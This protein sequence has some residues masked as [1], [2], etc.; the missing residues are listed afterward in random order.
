MGMR[1]KDESESRHSLAQQRKVRRVVGTGI[2][3]GDR[4]IAEYIGICA[5][6]RH[7]RCVR[8]DHPLHAR[9]DAHELAHMQTSLQTAQQIIQGDP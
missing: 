3:H 2:E 8:C 1:H 9:R 4:R 5:G 6:T 7:Q